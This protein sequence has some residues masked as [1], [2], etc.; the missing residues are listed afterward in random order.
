MIPGTHNDN[1]ARMNPI[2]SAYCT[3]DQDGEGGP[4]QAGCGKYFEV[5][6]GLPSENG[7]KFCCYCGRT[8]D[9]SPY[10]EDVEV[11]DLTPQKEQE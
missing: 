2:E 9:E 1:D 6:E 3:W 5:N 10:T 4:W 11:E 7:M 8:I